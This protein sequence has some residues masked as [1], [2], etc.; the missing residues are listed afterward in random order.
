MTRK[1]T[2][3]NLDEFAPEAEPTVAPSPDEAK[4]ELARLALEFAQSVNDEQTSQS[5]ID[6]A[7]AFL[8]KLTV[9]EFADL[10]EHP[11]V[12]M[13]RNQI[14]TADLRP[15]EVRNRGTLAEVARDWTWAD[16]K[17]MET[18]TFTPNE[19]IRITFNGV[20]LQ[21][22][23][24]VEQTVPRPFYDIYMERKNAIRQ[25]KLNEA[26]MLGHS[27]ELPHPNWQ[28]PEMAE[29]RA[30]SIAGRQYGRPGGTLGVGPIYQGEGESGEG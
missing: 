18:K 2:P 6:Q 20:A 19:S 16:M 4:A 11:F 26:Y 8:G 1:P 17:G 21:L 29:V 25:A 30:F 23:A 10:A 28:T 15:G 12:E 9:K 22:M 13:L 14:P 5:K 7:I 24:D 27:D 3:A